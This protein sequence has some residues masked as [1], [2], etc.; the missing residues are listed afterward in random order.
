MNKALLLS[1]ALLAPSISAQGPHYPGD[2]FFV[3][4]YGGNFT[5]KKVNLE[6]T[7]TCD[8]NDD[9]DDDTKD[10][11]PGLTFFLF[12]FPLSSFLFPLFSVLFPLSRWSRTLSTAWPRRFDH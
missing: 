12:L 5:V 7:G 9:D 3:T 11:T 8:N 4:S 2:P 6:T 1:A 10:D